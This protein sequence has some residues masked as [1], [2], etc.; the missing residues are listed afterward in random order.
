MRGGLKTV[1]AGFAMILSVNAV[2]AQ[3]GGNGSRNKDDFRCG[4][5]IG[6]NYA[7]V[8]DERGE[9]FVADPKLGFA[10]GAF[11]YI[12]VVRFIGI[13]PEVLYGQ[14]GFRGSGNADG[15]EYTIVRTTSHIDVPLMLA[16]RLPVI[17][18][19]AGP[20]YSFLLYQ[21]DNFTSNNMSI[22][23]EQQFENNDLRKNTLG[24]VGGVDI[25]LLKFVISGRAGWDVQ[26]NNGDG[27]A[28]N[29]D[30]KNAWVQG[31]VGIKF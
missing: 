23:I 21:R 9:N 1:L 12:P 15:G 26:S 30:Y 17:T 29:P 28:T 16:L 14:K 4:I 22:N 19:V 18:F 25:T 20:Q 10:G 7:N 27:T 31:T 13:Q 6:A 11:L 5:K 24:L 3:D 2:N 8:Y